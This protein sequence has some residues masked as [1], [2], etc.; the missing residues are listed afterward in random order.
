M[1][2]ILALDTNA[3]SDWMSQGRCHEVVT[4]ADRIL[5]ST[6]VLGELNHGFLKGQRTAENQTALDTF[7]R[8]PQVRVAPQER[9]MAEIYAQLLQHLRQKGTPIPTNDIWITT[10][11]LEHKAPRLTRDRYFEQVPSLAL[12]VK[13]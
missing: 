3:Y 7:L 9:R 5:L 2:L 1:D 12:N 8:E 11:A 13:P 4:L 6:P 10:S